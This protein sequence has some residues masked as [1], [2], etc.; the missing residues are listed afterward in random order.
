[1]QFRLIY[2]GALP[3]RQGGNSCVEKHH[4]RQQFHQQLKQLWKETYFLK[5]ALE[6]RGSTRPYWEHIADNYQIESFRFLPLITRENGLA[7]NLDILFLRRDN[8]GNLV[9]HGGDIDNR[10]K[11]LFDALRRPLEKQ[12]LQGI[13]PEGDETPFFC[14]LDDDQL[15]TQISVT[16]DRLLTPLENA[17][18]IHDVLL[19]IHVKTLVINTRKADFEFLGNH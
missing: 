18:F 2:K 12:E 19:I 9:K 14:L 3:S 13:N 11:V 17:E 16:T 5:F 10:I 4:I 1:M 15:I 6:P 8:P 7:C